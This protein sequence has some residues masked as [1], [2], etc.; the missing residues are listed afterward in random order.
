M[1]MIPLFR[2]T[3]M[4][5][6]IRFY[7]TILDFRLKYPE[8]SSDDWVIDLIHTDSDAELMLTSLE[9]DQKIGIAV[10][11]RVDDVDSLFYKFVQRGLDVSKKKESPVHQGPIDQTWGMREF[12]VTDSDGNTLRYGTPSRKN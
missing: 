1:K 11:V 3:D 10:N 6:A 9:G 2:C 4:D 12:Y 7:T 8:A 5:Q